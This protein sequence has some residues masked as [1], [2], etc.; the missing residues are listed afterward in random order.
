MGGAGEEEAL[1][2]AKAY[3][4]KGGVDAVMIHSKEKSP[5]EVLS[6]LEAYSKFDK[7][8]PVVV[9]PTSYNSLTEEDLVKAG[10]SICIHA[11]HLIRAA[12]PAM[13]DVA[14]TILSTG[15][16]KE[17]EDKNQ[18]MSVKKILNLISE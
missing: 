13:M 16:S 14:E 7:K 5:D 11:N 9:V 2:R 8:V 6:F 4:E 3:I 18:V 17:V 12:Y 1:K 15:R 10:A